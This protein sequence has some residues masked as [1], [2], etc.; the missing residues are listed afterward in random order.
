MFKELLVRC[1]AHLLTKTGCRIGELANIQNHRVDLTTGR[2]VVS[3][4]TSQRLTLI[5]DDAI[6][7]IK[8]YRA[9]TNRHTPDAPLLMRHD[10]KAGQKDLAYQHSH[11][12]KYCG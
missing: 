4:K 2:I 6:A 10:K 9:L 7:A 1:L 8:K 3:G 11:D 5:D 12:R